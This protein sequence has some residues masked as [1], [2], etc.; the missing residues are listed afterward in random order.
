M[1]K[2]LIT[3]ILALSLCAS[4]VGCTKQSNGVAVNTST[5]QTE[6]ISNSTILSNINISSG[7]AESVGEA[8]TFIELGNNITVDGKGATVDNNKVTITSAGTYSIKGS[9]TD[10]QIIV[11]AGDED[12]VYI[13]LNGVNIT[14]SNSAPIYIK[15][16]KK[17]IISLADNTA[18]NIKDGEN[19]VFEGESTDE[20]NAAIFSKSD[21][22]FIGNGS[23]TVDAKYNNG[24][25]SKDDLKIESGNIIVNSK[26]DGLRGKDSVVITNGNITINSGED[27]MKST[28][29][30]DIEKGYILIEGGKINITSG[31]DGIQAETNA[32]VKDGDI[33]INT[34]GGSKN[35]AVKEEMGPGMGGK[36][37]N[38]NTTTEATTTEE[39]SIST[40]AI[41]S[42][43]NIIIEG[44][45]FNIDSAND[46]F[47]SNNNLVIN[48][49]TFN[50]SSGDDGLHSDSTLTINDGNIN[51]AKSY[52]GIESESITINGGKIS[53]VSSDDG[54]NASSSSES[55]AGNGVPTSKGGESAGTGKLNING[56]KIS[57]NANGDGLDANG[58]IYM[59]GGT[60]IVNGPSSDGNAAL[61]YDATFSAT[62][63]VF[64]VAGSAGMAQAP[65]SESTQNSIKV[66]LSSQ[67]ANTLVRVENADGEEVVTFAP[68]KQY[69]SFVIASEKIKTGST[70]K[71]Y[72]GGSSTGTATDG[73]YSEGTYSKGEEIGSAT[74]SSSV[75]EITQSGVIVTKGMGGRG[76]QGGPGGKGAPNSVGA[77]GEVPKQ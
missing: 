42:G 60:V 35:A 5:T 25:T 72:V 45:T 50:I 6:T 73:L 53:L 10:G 62:G 20:P 69:A 67:T 29:D 11:N 52:E 51:I 18:N 68:S 31:K 57:V 48:A 24:I 21:L 14:S 59:K 77:A 65:S 54:F 41:K 33:T 22:I 12:K 76:G 64:I 38:S 55:A 2:K 4:I 75:T 66:T 43:V 13:I 17:A 19:Y 30:E 16:A 36:Q 7:K 32:L 3:V 39:E 63:G 46:A 61:D 26:A 74:I 71:V 44:G 58:S 9:L 1:K 37:F 49:G 27:G 56:G 23:L 40:K 28:N 8:N 15:N 34:G 47:H 70:Y